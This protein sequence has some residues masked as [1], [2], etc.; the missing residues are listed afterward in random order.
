MKPLLTQFVKVFPEK[1]MT[2]MII[3]QI[4]VVMLDKMID[5]DYEGDNDNDN[6]DHDDNADNDDNDDSVKGA[7]LRLLKCS[8]KAQVSF[9]FHRVGEPLIMVEIVMKITFDNGRHVNSDDNSHQFD[10]FL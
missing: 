4:A 3:K 1:T 8:V 10:H 5:D 7:K 2:V 9:C 6:D